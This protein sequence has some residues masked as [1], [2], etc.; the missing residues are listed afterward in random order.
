[1]RPD[2][3]PTP[4]A[5]V[6]VVLVLVLAAACEC[7]GRPAGAGPEGAGASAP[8]SAYFPSA[9]GDRWR[10][11]AGDDRTTRVVVEADPVDAPAPRRVV[12]MGYDLMGPRYH[13]V[14]DEAV[15][16]TDP[17]GEAL[18]T[19]LD[20]PMD[21][22]HEWRYLFGDV[23]C[24][25]TYASV[26]E[27]VEVAGL[28]LRACVL[29]ERTCTHPA[30]KPFAVETAEI[31]EETY[32]PQVGR[33]REHMR[34]EPPPPGT[35]RAE[36]DDRLVFYRVAGSPAPE[37]PETF[38][39]DSFLIASTDVAAAC[40]RG[41]PKVSDEATR[42]GCRVSFAP[43]P[44]ATP[45]VVTGRR[46]DRDATQADVDALVGAAAASLDTEEL[47]SYGYRHGAYALA[48]A[49]PTELCAADSLDRLGPLLQSLVRR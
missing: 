48:V 25:A 17:E 2:S 36:R 7:G 10:Y 31:H 4:A 32:C 26:D 16:I 13:R 43:T 30:G 39:C 6:S 19:L 15:V 3:T 35:E 46:F 1:M 49:S 12:V 44:T 41:L 33:V 21:L 18:G 38:D 22:G 5:R 27:T 8:L 20:A 9:P 14:S 37:V 47:A 28:T 24:E 29:V 11:A 40:G 23:A 34:I 42:E 45:L